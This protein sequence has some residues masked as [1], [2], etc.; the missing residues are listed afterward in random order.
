[1]MTRNRE[2][3][4]A[5]DALPRRQKRPWP[6][7]SLRTYTALILA[8]GVIAIIGLAQTGLGRAGLRAAGLVRPVDSFSELYFTHPRQIQIN[9][10]TGS[11]TIPVSFTIHNVTS[12]AQSYQ[13]SVELVDGVDTKHAAKGEVT[14]KQ[15]S[16]AA[17]AKQV[18]GTCWSG[19]L[20]VVVRLVA[21]AESIDYYAGC[22]SANGK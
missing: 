9:L 2:R 7:S 10:P 4:R 21:P 22:S 15:D 19:Q 20:Q 6:L 5:G 12:H 13:W 3:G 16:V 1:M 17:I 14:V 11:V 18:S 8:L